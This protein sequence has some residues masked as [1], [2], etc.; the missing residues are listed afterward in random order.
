MTLEMPQPQHYRIRV[1]TCKYSDRDHLLTLF[2]V[3]GF[4]DTLFNRWFVLANMSQ[5]ATVQLLVYRVIRVGI[6][7]S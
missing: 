1:G 7:S 5:E 4:G 3:L 6:F 2:D